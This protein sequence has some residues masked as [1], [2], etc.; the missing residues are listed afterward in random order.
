MKVDGKEY[1]TVMLGDSNGDGKV[2]PADATIVLRKYV[3]SIDLSSEE[4][5]AADAN[6]D[7]KLTPADSTV[8]LRNYVGLSNIEI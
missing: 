6:R 7:G 8:I 1:T 3:G 5:K 4:T 2:T